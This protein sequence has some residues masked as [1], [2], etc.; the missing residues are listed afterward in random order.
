MKDE[1]Y[2]CLKDI[3]PETSSIRVLDFCDIY[4]TSSDI[5]TKLNDVEITIENGLNKI[6]AL[7]MIK[8]LK[9]RLGDIKIINIGNTKCFINFES[10]QKKA[11]VKVILLIFSVLVLFFGGA[12]TIMNFHNDVNMQ[13]VYKNVFRFFGGNGDVPVLMGILYSIGVFIGFISILNVFSKPNRSPG[14]LDLEISAHRDKVLSFKQNYRDRE[15][16]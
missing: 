16:Q 7:H 10:K 5:E 2:F 11:Y 1:L 12:I 14:I 3:K 6:T 9:E 13:G 4:T 15:R 8:L